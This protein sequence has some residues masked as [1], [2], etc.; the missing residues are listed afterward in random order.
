MLWTPPAH[1]YRSY[2]NGSGSGCVG[3]HNGFK[4]GSGP[5]HLQHRTQFG[6]TSCNLCHPSGNGTTP[7]LTYWSGPGGGLGCAGCHGQDYGETSPNSGEPKATGYGLREFHFV[8]KGI[9]SCGPSSCHA[10]GSLGHSNPFPPLF[11]ENVPPPY[12]NPTFSSLTDPCSSAQEDIPFDADGV[13][14]DNDGDGLVDYPSDPDCPV[15]PTP[16]P[17]PVFEC[18]AAPATG[19]IDA[20]KGVLLV[21]EKTAGKEKLKVV[22]KKLQ[23]SVAASQF[24]DPV[25]GT[26]AYKICIY[27]AASQL[28]GEY[29]LS[30]AGDTCGAKP[31]WSAV[32]TKGYKYRDKS[33]VADGLLVMK[34]IGGDAGK[35]KTL[36]VG[37]NTAST[38]PTG[39]AA[40]LQNET[41]ATVQVLTSDAA[42]FGMTLPQVK[43]ADGL[44]FKAIGP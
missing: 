40:A 22:L 21:N 36:A 1:A 19:C 16:T 32:S 15:P 29:T 14:L 8:Q 26:T 13:G 20:G 4:G 33:T 37:K 12:Y 30:R 44:R 39:V 42:C 25:A 28:K 34:L 2:D 23:P 18:G 5:L 43:Q 7:V 35:G 38:L 41:G 27:N 9:T 17:T 10:P 24:G 11:G 3:C 31:C 6:A